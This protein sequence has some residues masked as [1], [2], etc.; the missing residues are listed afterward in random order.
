MENIEKIY[1]ML[2]S[3]GYAIIDDFLPVSVADE[4]Y[5]LYEL[6]HDWE[7]LD[8]VRDDH[9]KHVFK[10]ELL[11]FPSGDEKYLARFNRSKEIERL[12]RIKEIFDEYFK[13]T[14]KEVSKL[15]LTEFDTR[16]Y[17]LEKGDF[18]RVHIDD[19]AGKINSIYYVNKKWVWDWGGILHVG[20]HENEDHVV[21]IFPK[22]NRLVLLHNEKFRCPHYINT[23]SEFAGNSRY[24]MVS[25]N[26]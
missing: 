2:N 16:C 3:Q 24:T 10:T 25:F 20:S 13:P 18:Y 15:P 11:N 4:I 8:Q 21:P 9:Y 12:D 26:K 6:E 14:I 23:V 17:K 19:Y 1:E 7:R 5:D 22:F